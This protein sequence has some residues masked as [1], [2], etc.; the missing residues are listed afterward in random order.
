MRRYY[1]GPLRQ[2]GASYESPDATRRRRRMRRGELAA[3]L[4]ARVPRLMTS[5][6]EEIRAR[7][8]SRA[9]ELDRVTDAFVVEITRMLPL[10]LGPLRGQVRPLWI[11]TCELFGSMAVRRGLAA[12]EVIEEFLLLRELVIRELYKDPPHGG[13]RPL[14]LPETLRLNRA[15]DQAVTYA[16]IGHTDALFYNLLERDAGVAPPPTPIAAEAESQLQQI[17]HE[18][19]EIL[20]EA[21]AA[22]DEESAAASQDDGPEG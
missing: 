20:G 21:E 7:A 8:G 10:L 16:S 13:R 3:W 15:L 9:G 1:S 12:G 6:I 14:S 17:R 19:L 18:L 4:Q 5:W 22:Q 11:R 2:T